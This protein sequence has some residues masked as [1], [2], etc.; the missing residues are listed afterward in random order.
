MT[1]TPI[2]NLYKRKNILSDDPYKYKADIF[3]TYSVAHGLGK[4]PGQ[5]L[6]KACLYW[7]KNVE[8]KDG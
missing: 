4:T 7:I 1:E 3:D 6:M 5:A 2:V 8:K